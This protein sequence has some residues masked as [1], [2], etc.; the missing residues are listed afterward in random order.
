MAQALTVSLLDIPLSQPTLSSE[1]LSG[2]SG[3]FSGQLAQRVIHTLA[4]T[5]PKRILEGQSAQFRVQSETE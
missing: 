3:F 4:A 1:L 5:I 2:V